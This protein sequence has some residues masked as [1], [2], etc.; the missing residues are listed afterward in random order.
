[1][2]IAETM[3]KMAVNPFTP[4]LSGQYR[5]SDARHGWSDNSKAMSRLGW[6]PRMSFDSGV[7]DLMQWL[8]ELPRTEIDGAVETFDRVEREAE[9][10]GLVV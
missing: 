1:M 9:A 10:K 8:N 5:V 3:C 6:A 2:E 7:A 4:L